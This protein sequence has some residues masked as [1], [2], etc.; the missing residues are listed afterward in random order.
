[1]DLNEFL[2]S[3]FSKIII[4][5]ACLLIIAF[6]SSGCTSKQAIVPKQIT[7][8][9]VTLDAYVP[10]GKYGELIKYDE[11]GNPQKY[12]IVYYG[13]TDFD[14]F[15]SEEYKRAQR[16][17]N[18]ELCKNTDNSITCIATIAKRLNNQSICSIA[19]EQKEKCLEEYEKIAIL[20]VLPEWRMLPGI[21]I[22][23]YDS[24]YLRVF[25]YLPKQGY[26]ESI[27]P[28]R[29]KDIDKYNEEVM[30]Y[31]QIIE[32]EDLKRCLELSF[33]ELCVAHIARL[34]K[35]KDVC[36]ILEDTSE[37]CYVIYDNLELSE[38][39]YYCE[40]Q[41]DCEIKHEDGIIDIDNEN[42]PNYW[43]WEC[44]KNKCVWICN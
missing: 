16:E 30:L 11:C 31:N 22:S 25:G 44:Q 36:N 35:Q 7:K 28:E 1:M 39:A 38:D 17:N 33:K 12:K 32:A 4:F 29:K 9:N 23:D 20:E 8:D 18:P 14:A 24:Y 37:K 26:S 19:N 15:S 6:L 43:D 34:K 3:N 27:H 13:T 10:C 5:S 41:H 42:C 2:K 40:L 21:L